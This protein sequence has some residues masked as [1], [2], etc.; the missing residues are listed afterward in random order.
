MAGFHG[1]GVGVGMSGVRLVGALGRDQTYFSTGNPSYRTGNGRRG[2][3]GEGAVP[4]A[5]VGPG[6]GGS[7]VRFQEELEQPTKVVLGRRFL[8][9]PRRVRVRP[10]GTRLLR[11]LRS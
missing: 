8:L 6:S 1:Q 2:A 10:K 9:V 3:A 5:G 4:G 7:R 11:R